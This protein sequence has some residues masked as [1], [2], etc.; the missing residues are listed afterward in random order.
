P[1]I[2]S[3]IGFPTPGPDRL[4][5]LRAHVIRAS[6][7][8]SHSAPLTLPAAAA[9]VARETSALLSSATRARSIRPPWLESTAASVWL[10]RWS[11]RVAAAPGVDW[12]EAS[13]NCSRSYWIPGS[14]NLRMVY[15]D[16]ISCRDP[17]SCKFFGDSV[18]LCGSLLREPQLL[19]LLI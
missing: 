13:R 15:T 14:W 11:V 9:M 16:D 7:R 8:S 10:C 19:P 12:R 4:P 2:T 18:H 17:S 1:L 5:W 6:S 3:Q